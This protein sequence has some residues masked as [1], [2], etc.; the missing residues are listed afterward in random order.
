MP[1]VELPEDLGHLTPRAGGRAKAL[2]A[3]PPTLEP[4]VVTWT[5]EV[6]VLGGAHL[7]RKAIVKE[8][9]L[10]LRTPEWPVGRTDS[11]RVGCVQHERLGSLRNARREQ[12]RHRAGSGAAED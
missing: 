2:E 5:L 4:L 12:H 3:G 9:L 11:L 7:T 1:D 10:V 8:F 6:E